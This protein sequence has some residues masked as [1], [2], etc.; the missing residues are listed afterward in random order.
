MTATLNRRIERH[1]S[2]KGIGLSPTTMRRTP[3]VLFV[4]DDPDIQTAFEIRMRPF[5]IRVKH[6]FFGAQGIEEAIKTHPDLILMDLAMPN[7]NG[8]YLLETIKRNQATA[9]IPVVVLTGMRD[10]TIKNRVLRQGAEGFLRKPASFD[11]LLHEIGRFIDVDRHPR[12]G[13]SR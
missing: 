8:E 10:P 4:D 5:A 9:D 13:R 2:S 3:T 7:G 11:D 6:A 12:R 1:L